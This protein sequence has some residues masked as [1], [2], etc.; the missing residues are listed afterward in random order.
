MIAIEDMLPE[1]SVDSI[2]AKIKNC[3]ASQASMARSAGFLMNSRKCLTSPSTWA[4]RLI[5]VI[6]DCTASASHFS[7]TCQLTNGDIY[8]NSEESASGLFVRA[9]GT[10]RVWTRV[11]K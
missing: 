5:R 3:S 2:G 6:T 4:G 1:T 9:A 8:G 10:Y 11:V 7:M